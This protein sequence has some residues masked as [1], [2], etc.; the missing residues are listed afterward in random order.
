[1]NLDEIRSDFP[2]L[3]RQA[4]SGAD[5]VYLDNA[6]SSQ[7]PISVIDAMDDCYRRYYSN[8]HRGIHTLSE[9]STEHFELARQSVA[10][11]I[12]ASPIE[13]IFT[14]GTT[15]AI[16]L[17]A[18]SWGDSRI[19][20]DDVI[21]LTIAEHHANIVPW[22]QLS[23][24]TGCRV[25]F[26]PLADNLTI[27]TATVEEY[28]QRLRPKMFAFTAA[29]NVLGTCNPV[30]QWTELA[31]Q[32]DCAVLVDAA[33]AVPH[34]SVDVR[35]WDAD[36]IAFG[37]HKMCGPSG[38]GVLYGKEHLLESMPPFL[39]GGGMIRRVTTSGFES[40][41]LPEKFEAG[42]P[43]IAES[44]GL[45]AGIEYLTEIG[46]DQIAKH[47]HELS[48]AA[49]Q[50]LREIEGVRVVGPETDDKVGIVSF[51]IDH[52]HAHD[53]AQSLDQRG[54]AVRAGHH[55]TMPLH[56]ALG[57]TATTRAS[58]YLYNTMDEV[59]QLISAVDQVRQRFAPS[60]RRRKR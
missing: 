32:V 58:F 7:R 49:E 57:L 24:R 33:Q 29:S 18:Y 31:R 20:P 40:G 51:Y 3:A 36:F 35:Q 5:L 59:D 16:N 34:Q 22:H 60:G 13:T 46:L 45:K 30:Q 17:V 25:E 12:N 4:A 44:I 26:L 48:A 37:G 1:V 56:A 41:D 10:G 21:L 9:E 15:A 6:A 52:A 42:T 2:I 54:I 55:C 23:E 39:G 47:E 14:A 11:F 53:V 43:P 27:H 38:I 8:V 28:L 50:R 19:G